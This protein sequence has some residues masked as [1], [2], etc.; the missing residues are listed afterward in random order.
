MARFRP[1]RAGIINLWDY[2]DEE[3]LFVEGWLVLRGP[4][5]SGKT[6]ALELLFPYLLD[7]RIEPRRLNP[8]AGEERTMK[9]N[10]LYRGQES[11]HGYVWMEF[12]DG[13]RHVTIGIG[14]RAHRHNDRV[15]R[16]HFVTDGR[17]GVDLSLLDS[18]DRPLTRKDLIASLGADS[19]RDSAEEYRHLVDATLFGL[20]PDRYEQMLDLVLTLRKPQLAK[21]LNPVELSR[22]LQRGLRPVDDHLLVE[23][24]RAFD[25]MEAVARTLEGL[26]AADTACAAFLTVYAT[27]LRTHA[28]AAADALT[29]RRKDADDR[30][31]ELAAARAAADAADAAVDSAQQRVRA[32][33]PEPAR[34]RAHLDR[35]KSSAAYRS[36]EQLADVQRHLEDLAAA[37]QRA[38]DAAADEQRAEAR[39]RAERERALVESRDEQTRLS[40]LAADLAA[41][42]EAAGIPWSDGD[43][44]P[45]GLPA[46]LSARSQARRADVRA[47][48]AQADRLA[49]ADRERTQADEASRA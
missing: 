43:A 7:G 5:G 17:V 28:R 14:L 46:R 11:A 4:N 8:F 42:A 16:W 48:R 12:S 31:R 29:S 33:E 40:R 37:R 6:K 25:D 9:S 26:V 47:V 13:T 30:E 3:F 27:Y 2:R 23:A 10:L 39:R 34:L 24:A 35:L 1:T 38:D 18:D 36:H 32:A 49:T 19:V 20:G 15:T 45:D 44:H 22:T 41:D 21:D